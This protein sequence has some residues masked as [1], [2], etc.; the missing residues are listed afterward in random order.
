MIL[1]SSKLG[2][3]F[4]LSS[5]NLLP[6]LLTNGL[7]VVHIF[8]TLWRLNMAQHL[9]MSSLLQYNVFEELTLVL[10]RIHEPTI[11]NIMKT[12]I[13]DVWL[14]GLKLKPVFFINWNSNWKS[15]FKQIL[16]RIWLKSMWLLGFRFCI[17]RAEIVDKYF[18]LTKQYIEP[19]LST[20]RL[21]VCWQVLFWWPLVFK[22]LSI[23]DVTVLGVKDFVT[24]VLRP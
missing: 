23:N 6:V 7:I 21:P 19:T 24:T 1:V 17:Q 8:D 10:A 14:L 13:K 3:K 15:F 9:C 20:P 11:V 12:I 5:P 22:G 2:Y 18:M 4:D 16:S